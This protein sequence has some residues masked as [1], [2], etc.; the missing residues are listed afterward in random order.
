MKKPAFYLWTN[1]KSLGMSAVETFPG[2]NPLEPNTQEPIAPAEALPI[3]LTWLNFL[4]DW[5]RDNL[6]IPGVP[7][8]FSD[9]EA[10]KWVTGMREEI[11]QA[12]TILRRIQDALEVEAYH[13]TI[14]KA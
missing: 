11:Q 14:Y 2:P 6:N 10:M 4:R 7:N 1:R 3:Q 5:L 8:R 13:K 9:S 12:E